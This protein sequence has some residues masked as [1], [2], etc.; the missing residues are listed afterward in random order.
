MSIINLVL[1][2]NEVYENRLD[3]AHEENNIVHSSRAIE[4]LGTPFIFYYM[5]IRGGHLIA[6]YFSSLT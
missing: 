2:L 5:P 6:S 1:L 3:A 4:I